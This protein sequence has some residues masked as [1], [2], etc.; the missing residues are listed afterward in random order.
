MI[1]GV[2]VNLKLQNGI[3][4]PCLC[5]R[6]VAGRCVDIVRNFILLLKLALNACVSLTVE[7]FE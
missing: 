4:F 7:N 3:G 2:G 6:K 5:A 1:T